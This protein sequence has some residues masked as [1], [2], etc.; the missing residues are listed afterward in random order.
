MKNPMKKSEQL[1]E[2]FCVEYKNRDLSAVLHLFTQNAS[3][4]GTVVDEYHVGLKEIRAQLQRD[5]QQ[6]E[7]GEIMIASFMPTHEQALWTT[8]LC[9]TTITMDNQACYFENLRISIMIEQENHIWKIAHMHAS[10][11]DL[12]SPKGHSFPK[13]L[14]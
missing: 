12:R 3:M 2:N 5:W 8:A 10:F 4:I 11:P 6:S 14:V 7:Q 13:L 1:L 9:N